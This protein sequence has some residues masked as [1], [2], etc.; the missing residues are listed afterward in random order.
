MPYVS[1]A[2]LTN[3]MT[4]YGGSAI[5]SYI[6]YEQH[7]LH[8]QDVWFISTVSLNFY[9]NVSTLVMM[10]IKMFTGK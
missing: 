7:N 8:M 3:H 9:E 5:K 1:W 4:I 2:M 6:Q 10:L